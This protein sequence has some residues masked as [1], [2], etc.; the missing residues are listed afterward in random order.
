LIED[1]CAFKT[2]L[3]D[4]L[5]KGRDRLLELHSYHPEKAARAIAE[6]R[7][8]EQDGA[9]RELLFDLMEHYG[10]KVVEH[11]NGQCFIS[12]ENAYLEAFPSL[13][14]QGCLATFSRDQAVARED[15]V[16]LTMDHP[17]YRDALE[18]MLA[19]PSG[20]TAFVTRVSEEQ[21]LALECLFM[22][23]VVAAAKWH[24]E[25]F[26]APVPIRVVVDVR[27]RNRSEEMDWETLRA[28]LKDGAI[29]RFLEQPLFNLDLLKSLIS[30]A[31]RIGERR[32]ERLVQESSLKAS[33][34]LGLE[35]R[36]IEELQSRYGRIRP[37]ETDA[38]RE[39][40]EATLEAIKGARLRLD[41][42]RVIMSGPEAALKKV[43]A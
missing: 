4:H 26:L 21:S 8:Q 41:S 2:E 7:A 37:A 13:T 29:H 38:A 33:D 40:L 18:V 28:Q 11:E 12:S 24:V 30:G 19:S 39:R 3:C 6:V 20:S 15:I 27:G 31:Q 25:Q 14:A 35:C 34:Q 5:A 23:E 16:F 32:L 43:S 22:V 17:I 9:L 10:V 42:L 1:T 36:R